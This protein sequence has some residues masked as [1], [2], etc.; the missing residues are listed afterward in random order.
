MQAQEKEA[1][2][3]QEVLVVKSYTPKEPL[4]DLAKTEIGRNLVSS[5]GGLFCLS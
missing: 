5:N 1:L 4:V 2:K 3:I